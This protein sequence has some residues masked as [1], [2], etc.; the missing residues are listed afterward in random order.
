MNPATMMRRVVEKVPYRQWSRID[1]KVP[2]I[3]DVA[4]FLCQERFRQR[5]PAPTDSSWHTS[6]TKVTRSSF[7]VGGVSA[8]GSTVQFVLATS[9]RATGHAS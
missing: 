8:S 5:T 7:L 6:P 3:V 4:E 9:V 2:A 1:V